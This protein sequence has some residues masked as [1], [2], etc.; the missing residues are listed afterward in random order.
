M[1]KQLRSRTLAIVI[2]ALMLCSTALYGC[3]ESS[4]QSSASESSASSKSTVTESTSAE[5]TAAESTEEKSEA[6]AATPTETPTPEVTEEPEEEMSQAEKA[7]ISERA[8]QNFLDKLTVGDYVMSIEE[9]LTT[10][11]YSEDQVIFDYDDDET[12]SDFAVMSV[13]DEVFQGYLEDEAVGEVLFLTEG[14]AID[15]VG[16]RLP[17]YWVSEE[18]SE[19]NIFNLFYN[20]ADDPLKF[21]SYDPNL[22][23]QLLSMAGYSELA[24]N[25]MHE[26]Y[27]LLDA[28]DPTEAH[29]QAQVDNDEV[30]RYYFGDIDIA[31]TFGSAQSDP[32][33]EAWMAAP[34]YPEARTGWTESDIFVFNSIFLPGYGEE[35]I[36]FLPFASYA[37]TLN[38][39]SFLTDDAVC[40]RDPHATQE[41]IESYKEVLAQN[42]F[43]EVTEEDG[44]FY[45]KLLREETM[46]YSSI[47]LEYDEGL[48][49]AADKYY[50][51]PKYDD[52]DQIN[53]FITANGYPELP[54]TSA[55]TLLNAYDTANEQTESWL[56]F[57]DYDISLFVYAHYDDYDEVMTYLDEYAAQLVD[58]GYTVRY[59]DDDE[60]GEVDHYR[61]EDD[62][63]TFRYHFEDDYETVILLFRAE[64]GLTAEEAKAI[65]DNAGFPETDLTAYI[66][67]RDH[68]KFEKLMYGKDYDSSIT[69]TMRFETSAEAEE[70]LNDY[71][72][73]LED[74]EFYRVPAS[75]LGSNKQNGYTNEDAGLGV[76]FDFIPADDGGETFIYFDFKSGIE[77]DE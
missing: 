19:G 11:A 31:I 42:G 66:S 47:S 13:D 65:L 26:V 3:G 29:I 22:Q 67:G 77:F 68:T 55:M 63:K 7:Q 28:E 15:A 45:R 38:E 14:H 71:V 61:S 39:D 33:A 44:T 20:D 53:E 64:K 4:S 9:Y 17:N 73:L 69:A 60:E 2:A 36:P 16:N 58:A 24:L 5:S 62:S 70:F 46:C 34:E 6:P 56:Y 1:K 48:N 12:Y 10:T 72:A 37:L 18:L 54:E 8:I 27:L 74:N 76:G 32:R 21:V 75:G 51:F 50:V 30:A 57:Y 49:L 40:I 52:L 35:A 59:V 23:M 43:E 41:D 25:Y